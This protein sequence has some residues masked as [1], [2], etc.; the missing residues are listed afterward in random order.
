M[1]RAYLV[2][3]RYKEAVKWARQGRRHQSLPWPS[4]AIPASAL[5]HLDRLKE[6]RRALDETNEREPGITVEF[7]REH[8]TVSDA[9]Y[10]GHFLDGFRKVGLPE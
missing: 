7:V 6:A 4:L 10:I 1:A 2:L 9:D 5:A 8:T 3:H